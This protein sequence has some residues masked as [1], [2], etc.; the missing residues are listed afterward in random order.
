MPLFKNQVIPLKILSMSSD[1]NGIG[2]YDGQAVFVPFSAPRDELF[3]KI[4]KVQNSYA[5]G[6]IDSFFKESDARIKPD[7]DIFGKCGGCAFRHLTYEQEL[8]EKQNMVEDSITRLG[9]I[10]ASV[11]K[12]LP[13]PNVERYRNK[14][15]L[16]LYQDE[17]GVH[18]GFYAGR[19]HRVIPCT[20]CF[21]Q[22]AIFTEIASFLCDFFTKNN[23]PVYNEANHTG[24]LRH[25]YLRH[26]VTI[27]K[28]MV[29]LVLNGK[30]I[31]NCA[32]LIE[33]LTAKFNCISGLIINV[34]KQRTNVVL[35]EKCLTMFGEDVLHDTLSDVPVALNPLS[36]YQINTQGAEQLYAVAFTF[37]NLKPTD[38]LLDLYCGA[39]TIGLSMAK[40]C[41]QV[42]G[43]E[44]VPEAIESAKQNAAKMGA[45]NT[46]F[47]CA[48]ASV[49]AKS[50]LKEGLKPNV[51]VV[52]PPRKGCDEATLNA[53]GEMQVNS[54]VMVSC[55]PATA[56]RDCKHLV[57]LGYAVQAVQPVDMFPRTKHVECCVLLCRI[58]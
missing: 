7:C 2:K 27:G 14:V 43:V 52:D 57:N 58:Q 53:I 35:G 50:L 36:F 47:I 22:P 55:N 20:D 13:S 31:P 4:V 19:S 23:I 15:Q 6:I 10:S 32:Q 56:A 34:N 38:V 54:I 39:G 30:K 45:N 18:T 25:I 48:D 28:V 46:R 8:I 44:V 51:V 37:A 5:F 3:V 33:E 1:G 26:A 42:I 29:C 49:A 40:A 24:L 21:L 41:K 9:G 17:T 12:I 16:P 11:S